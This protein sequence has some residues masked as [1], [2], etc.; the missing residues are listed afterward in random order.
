MPNQIT[1]ELRVFLG[2]HK[3]KTIVDSIDYLQR[4]ADRI[5]KA[6]ENGV[7]DSYS[8]GR[9]DSG[10]DHMSNEELA[11]LGLVR[12]PKDAGGNIIKP[13]DKVRVFGDD[14]ID[15]PM[16]VTCVC[17]TKDGTFVA[18]TY[19][20]G[21]NPEST[22]RVRTPLER[23]NDVI[24][25]MNKFSTHD[26]IPNEIVGEWFDDLKSAAQDLGGEK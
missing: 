24:W 20:D 7:T 4:I 17:I 19:P 14:P 3:T 18:Q 22:H 12:F 21:Y 5:D 25:S 23:I 13:G 8:R 11:E 15:P 9:D 10:P 2:T 1:R 16:T 26:S 6:Y